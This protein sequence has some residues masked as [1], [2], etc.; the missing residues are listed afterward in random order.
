METD[1]HSITKYINKIGNT[2]MLKI[3]TGY[4][5]KLLIPETMKLLGSTK[6]KKTKDKNGENAPHLEITEVVLVHCNIANTKY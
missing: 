2:I 4:Y 1:N 6:S 5:L 3:K